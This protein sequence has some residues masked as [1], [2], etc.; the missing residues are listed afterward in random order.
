MAHDNVDVNRQ[1]KNGETA[2]HAAA[3]GE[4]SDVLKLLM[5]HPSLDVNLETTSGQSVREAAGS[6]LGLTFQTKKQQPVHSR[7]G[8]GAGCRI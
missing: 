2:V 6:V 3:K 4:H 1:N 7:P 5:D 8:K